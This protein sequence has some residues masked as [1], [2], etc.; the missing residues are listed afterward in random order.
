M[1][2][3][4]LHPAL[5][6]LFLITRFPAAGIPADRAGFSLFPLLFL[7]LLLMSLLGGIGGGILTPLSSVALQAASLPGTGGG[8]MAPCGMWGS[9]ADLLH[10]SRPFLN[11]EAFNILGGGFEQKKGYILH[12]IFLSHSLQPCGVRKPLRALGET[13]RA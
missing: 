10:R 13:S 5:P 3:P 9:G 12:P 4:A 11:F 6:H 2:P 1:Q 7:H 8:G